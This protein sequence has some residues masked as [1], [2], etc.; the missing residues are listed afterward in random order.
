MITRKMILTVSLGPVLQTECERETGVILEE[1]RG[2][3]VPPQV[4]ALVRPLLQSL[5]H[6]V[7]AVVGL[8]HRQMSPEKKNNACSQSRNGRNIPRL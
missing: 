8:G 1:L 6:L 3:R 7:D 5:V 2:E 4:V